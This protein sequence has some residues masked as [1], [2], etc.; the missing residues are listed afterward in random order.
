M[1]ALILKRGISDHIKLTLSLFRK[2]DENLD[3]RA[4]LKRTR[5]T[6]D[7]PQDLEDDFGMNPEVEK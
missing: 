4:S 1:K 5:V 3:A 6:K 2:A 7:D